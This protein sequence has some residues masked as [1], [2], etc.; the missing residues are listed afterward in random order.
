MKTR[1]QLFTF[2]FLL[3]HPALAVK[4]VEKDF[5]IPVLT[6]KGTR[7]FIKAKACVFESDKK[8][9]VIVLNHG[10]P[11][12]PEDRKIVRPFQC[13]NEAVKW[14]I[15]N[16]YMVVS[17]LRRGYGENVTSGLNKA[18][19]W[20]E[21]YGPCENADYKKAALEMAVDIKAT[22]DY[23]KN[24]PNAD[25]QKIA[26][27]GQSAGGL[28]AIALNSMEI[29]SVKAFVN[30]SGGYGGHQGPNQ[31]Q[32]CAPENLAKAVGIFAKTA[33]RR[34]LWLYTENDSYFPPK[35]SIAMKNA[36]EKNGGK[37]IF[38]MKPS[39]GIDGHRFLV[40]EG[41]SKVWAMDLTNYLKAQLK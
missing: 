39:F 29:S 22:V 4:V 17:P 40:A 19:D 35:I 41:G 33:K 9:G 23:L 26:V 16:G 8:H 30:F 37:L 20:S 38:S 14:F 6:K 7:L 28:G 11:P 32:N 25:S 27:I 12:R 5:Q 3:V 34:M 10:I 21:S 24:I 13:D 18:E 15:A 36:Y 1:L 2:V 31:D